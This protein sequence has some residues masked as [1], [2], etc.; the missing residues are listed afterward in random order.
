[1]LALVTVDVGGLIIGLY[2]AL[3]VRAFVVDPH[4]VL[5]GL[6]WDQETTGSRS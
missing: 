4:P 1:M 3:A 2:A 5:W 6:I